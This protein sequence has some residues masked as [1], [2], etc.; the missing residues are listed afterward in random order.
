MASS[1]NHFA[2]PGTGYKEV[3]RRGNTESLRSAD[4]MNASGFLGQA[5]AEEP[6]SRSRAFE[7]T[8]PGFDVFETERQTSFLVTGGLIATH[9]AGRDRGAIWDA[10]QRREVYGTSGPRILLWFDLLNAPSS[11]G[12]PLPM[13]GEVAMRSDPILQVKAVGSFLQ[14][15][16]CPDDTHQ[17]LSSERIEHLCKGECYHPSDQRRAITRIEIV[18]IRPQVH[19][20]EPLS[21][22]IDDPWRSYSCDGDPD[23]CVYTFTDPEFSKNSRDTLYYARVFEVEKPGIN[24]DNLRCERD[25]AGRCTQVDLC[26]SPDGSNPDCLAPHEPRAWSSPIYVDYGRSL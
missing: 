11:R 2:R 4:G 26:P 16:G 6:V 20:D 12:R 23:G 9:A 7:Y 19:A 1:D 21:G 8:T 22:L 14:K 17:A 13:G 15:P 25:A 24:A 10:M 18:R 5:P 3:H